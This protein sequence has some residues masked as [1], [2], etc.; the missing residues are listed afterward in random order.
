L[1]VS[2]TSRA[3]RVGEEEGREYF[4]VT[5]ER[6]EELIRED[7]LLEHAR[8]GQNYYGT[9]ADY[10][11]QKLSE[12]KNVILEIE[13]QGGLQ[14]KEKFPDTFLLYVVPP[15]AKELYKRLTERNTETREDIDRRM[16][17]AVEE[18]EYLNRYDHITVNDDFETCLE[19]IHRTIRQKQQALHERDLLTERLKKELIEITKGE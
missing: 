17:R 2:A 3:P 12:G 5:K 18:T 6:F 1:S 15:S 19:E 16:R 8:Y 14:I 10:V 13:V 7:R 9:P 4:F 11:K